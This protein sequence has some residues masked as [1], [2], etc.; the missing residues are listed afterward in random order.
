MIKISII[1]LLSSICFWDGGQPWVQQV[2]PCQPWA[3]AAP[4][5]SLVL[6]RLILLVQEAR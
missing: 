2:P 1:K 4:S 3:G 5:G 6:E